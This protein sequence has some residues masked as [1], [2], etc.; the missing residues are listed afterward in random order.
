MVGDLHVEAAAKRH[1]ECGIAPLSP[2]S[3]VEEGKIGTHNSKQ[4]MTERLKSMALSQGELRAKQKKVGAKIGAKAGS[5]I[6]IAIMAAEI[7]FDTGP[8]HDVLV[9]RRVPSV[10]V[11][12]VAAIIAAKV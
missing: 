3:Y 2:T 4:R 5:Q 6:K 7:G 8:F 11:N 1:R 10:Q 12:A 9:E